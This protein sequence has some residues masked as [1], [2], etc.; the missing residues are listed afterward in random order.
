MPIVPAG[1]VV[2]TVAVGTP[3]TP[4]LS[5]NPDK[6]ELYQT[7]TTNL[8]LLEGDCTTDGVSVT[9]P[10]GTTF[11]Q[12]GIICRLTAPFVVAI[13]VVAFPKRV[14]AD[15]TNENPGSP[16][17]I[18][19]LPDPIPAPQVILASL[20]PTNA[21]IIV[22]KKISI[23]H[24]HDRIEALGSITPAIDVLD[25]AALVKA[26]IDEMNFTGGNTTVTD[27]GA[28]RANV[29][30]NLDILDDVAATISSSTREVQFTGDAVTT[31][32]GAGQ[33]VV[34]VPKL[35]T[36]DEGIIVVPQTH[37]LNFTGAGV[38]AT[39][40]GGDPNQAN[41]AIPGGGGGGGTQQISHNGVPV[42]TD[43]DVDDDYE[44]AGPG[45]LGILWTV[46]DVG[47]SPHRAETRGY[48]MDCCHWGGCLFG[49]FTSVF[50]PPNPAPG[51]EV[52][53]PPVYPVSYVLDETL[54]T[55]LQVT[56]VATGQATLFMNGN[57]GGNNALT[58]TVQLVDSFP[59][60]INLASDTFLF[61]FDQQTINFSVPYTRVLTGVSPYTIKVCLQANSSS[62]GNPGFPVQYDTGA[63][64]IAGLTVNQRNAGVG[65]QA[66]MKLSRTGN[67]L[68]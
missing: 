41:I 6:K 8:G 39:M 48:Y 16:V 22:A 68:V 63:Q 29:A 32:P 66:I 33:A 54:G 1:S 46:A 14:V 57:V 30:V 49:P 26:N 23:R 21:T 53:S 58:V 44:D 62:G 36:K 25:D 31:S 51:P 59:T 61:A 17:T 56:G 40:D 12:N 47:G 37:K 9:V 7:H 4:V 20:S 38:T 42:V 52:I 35:I 27:G 24:L 50:L 5:F 67:A 2:K 18:E 3:Y 19:I 43:T 60:V 13:P 11:V 28:N 64:P 65:L 55:G 34:D 15:L 45:I 10:A